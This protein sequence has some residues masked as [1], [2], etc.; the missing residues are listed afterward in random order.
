MQGVIGAFQEIDSTIHA[1]EE[2]KKA[3]LGEITIFTPTPRHEFDEVMAR[4]PSGVR[5][6]TLGFGLAGVS[7]GFWIPIWISDYW[8]TVVGGKPVASWVPYTILGFEVMVL[9][10]ALGTVFAMFA[11]S[12]I[13]RL[14][15]TVGY[16]P[17]FSGGDFGVWVA[18]TPERADAVMDI[19]KKHGAQEVRR[20]R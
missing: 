18:T 11:L 1:V 12:R 17:R 13:P 14:T 20:E 2:L 16:D 3:H 10:G 4:G 15:A 7:F 9:V 5:K 8:P 6:F 19:M